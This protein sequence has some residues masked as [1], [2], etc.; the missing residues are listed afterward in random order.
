MAPPA[1]QNSCGPAERRSTT[2]VPVISLTRPKIS[3]K[4]RSLSSPSW[5]GKPPAPPRR[6]RSRP[7]PSP[8]PRVRRRARPERPPR[9][10]PCPGR[11]RDGTASATLGA[12][13]EA[14]IAQPRQVGMDHRMP[15]TDRGDQHVTDGLLGVGGEGL[16]RVPE[17]RQVSG[18]H[19]VEDGRL[20]EHPTRGFAASRA[21]TCFG[22]RWSGCWWVTS[23]ASRSV[24]PCQ[25]SL[26]LP[27]SSRIR[28][29][30]VSTSTAA[31][32]R[33]VICSMVSTLSTPD[34]PRLPPTGHPPD[35]TVVPTTTDRRTRHR[36]RHPAALGGRH[37]DTWSG[38]VPR[39][40][41]DD[42]SPTAG[43]VAGRD[44][45]GQPGCPAGHGRPAVRVPP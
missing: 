10:A 24:S 12:Q 23:T 38:Q 4:P 3:W 36:H 42:H 11:R 29:F 16:G 45:G 30:S 25:P 35:R 15:P 44:G 5:I 9:P 31:C 19:P 43:V 18:G 14:D 8:P 27:G 34:R 2:R 13:H 33:W 37:L 21:G 28:A 26:K 7:S 22:S 6:G 20:D 40:G 32:P 1:T 41:V 17:R 39:Y